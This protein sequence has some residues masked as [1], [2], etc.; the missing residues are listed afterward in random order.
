[1]QFR[2][3]FSR[4]DGEWN[5]SRDESRWFSTAAECVRDYLVKREALIPEHRPYL[6]MTCRRVT[7]WRVFGPVG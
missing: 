2:T 3:E 4:R 5:G 1:M 6:R 7:R